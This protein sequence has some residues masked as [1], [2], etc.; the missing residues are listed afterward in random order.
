MTLVSSTAAFLKNNAHPAVF[1]LA[2]SSYQTLFSPKKTTGEMDFWRMQYRREGKTLG[3]AHYEKTMREMSRPLGAK[4]FEDK[5]V[6]DFG[7]GPR[8]SLTWLTGN[9]HCIGIDVLATAYMNEF[10]DVLRDNQMT[11]VTC[12]ENH[13]PMQSAKADIIFTMNALDHVLNL[14]EMCDEIVRILKP[15]GYLIASF[16][17]GEEAT[18]TEPQSLDEAMLNQILLNNFSELSKRIA[19]K[20]DEKGYSYFF[21]EGELPDVN[22]GPRLMWFV[23]QKKSQLS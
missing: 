3:R 16:N 12:S 20:D 17:L 6:C 1:R 11:Y 23:G 2:K 5:V 4:D 10:P 9:A 21:A 7:C 22:D 14:Q 15:G 8:G 13:I 18:V 19:P